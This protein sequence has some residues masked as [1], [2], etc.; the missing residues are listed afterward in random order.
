MAS[1]P[2]TSDDPDFDE[3]PEWTKADFARAKP[4]S[5]ALP[6]ELHQSS[7]KAVGPPSSR[8]RR[9]CRSGYPP[10]SWTNIA[11]RVSDGRHAST[12]T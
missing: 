5:E 12:P 10:A 7:Q 6:A 11:R 2:L 3:N 8:Q 1:K 4:A 9:R